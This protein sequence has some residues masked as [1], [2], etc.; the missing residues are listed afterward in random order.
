MFR[1]QCPVG[2]VRVTASPTQSPQRDPFAYCAAVGTID[3]PDAR[4]VGE[5]VPDPV[6]RGMIRKGIVSADASRVPSAAMK[7]FCR[8]NPR[9]TGIPAAVTGRATVYAWECR[10]GEARAG[11]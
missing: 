8:A 11:R 7:D 2:G 6:V 1:G 4:Y 9:A 5:R 3:V 10:N